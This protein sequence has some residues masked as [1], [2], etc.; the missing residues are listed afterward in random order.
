MRATM[1]W[2]AALILTITACGSDAEETTTTSSTTTT[3]TTSPTT[4][5]APTTT[6]LVGDLSPVNGLPVDDSDLLDRRVLAVKIDNHANARPQS[7]L[8]EAEAVVELRVEGGLTRFIALFHTTDSEYLGPIRSAR[9]SD[10]RVV[11]PLGASMAISGGQPWVRSGISALGVSFL[12]ETAPGMF[13]I[14]GRRAPHNLYA[15]TIDLRDTAD[16][17]GFPDDG[18]DQPWLSFGEMPDD[19]A[20]ADSARIRFSKVSAATWEWDGE[21][22]TRTFGS[23]PSLFREKDGDTGPITADTVVVLFGRFYTAGPPPGQGGSAVPATDT[24]GTGKA[25]VFSEGRVVE[26]T[27]SREAGEDPFSLTT[28][29]GEPMMVPPGFLWVSIVPDVGDV[30][31][32]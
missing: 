32:N 8:Q 30:T 28:L 21:V 18:P 29:D 31:W 19:A 1:A 2:L 4:T 16:S 10:A 5:N 23:T 14:S 25:I 22:Y 9:P 15:S 26:G 11:L 6:A 20:T 7:G 17:R 27:W 3:S 13:R 12:T 24:V